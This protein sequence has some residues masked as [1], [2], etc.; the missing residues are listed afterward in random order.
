MD[1]TGLKGELMSLVIML[2][3]ISILVI[4]HEFGHLFVA[5]WCGVKVERFG[6]GLPI[7]PT[8]AS[9]KA[10]DI[11]WCL[12]PLLFGG[13]VAFPDD[14]PESTV[15]E[16]STERFENQPLLNRAAIALAG[17]T[18]NFFMG[19][20]L[21]AL[22]LAVWGA[23]TMGIQVDQSLNAIGTI[24]ERPAVAEKITGLA[25]Q[26]H[27]ITG[28]ES[29][30]HTLWAFKSHLLNDQPQAMTLLAGSKEIPIRPS[31][32]VT[33]GLQHGDRVLSF[34][35][36]RLEERF[37]RGFEQFAALRKQ[38][39]NLPTQLTIERAGVTE[40]V[41]VTPDRNGTIGFSVSIKEGTETIQPIEALGVSFDFLGF[42]V[43]KN[44]EGLGQLIS[45][46]ADPKT[47]SGPIGIVSQGADL[48]ERSGIEKGLML[49]AIISVILAVMNLLPIP[50]L[51]G[52]HLLFILIE[53]AKGSPL[54]K[55]WQERI[56]GFGFLLLMAFMV[57]VVYNDVVNTF[58]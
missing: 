13:Y 20:G 36:E 39:A 19:W 24:Q 5:R 12:H 25:Y 42:I 1:A 38:R 11:E 54:N 7:G 23:S 56:T 55:V 32:A 37:G 50:P 15:P 18:V 2:L 49:T 33:A 30:P 8:L 9:V 3:L 16:D 52:S 46:Q 31:T 35:G 45:G 47:L 44:F 57:F 26:G 29:I 14:S 4:A 40:T 58:L 27:L 28:K 48:I 17:I 43:Q 41:T 51:D 10:F 21:M 34:H 22:V 6:L 53:A